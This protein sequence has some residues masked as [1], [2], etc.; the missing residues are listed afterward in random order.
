MDIGQFLE[1]IFEAQ[2]LKGVENREEPEDYDREE[3]DMP[4]LVDDDEADRPLDNH[5][6]D[7]A[8]DEDIKTASLELKFLLQEKRAGRIIN[9]GGDHIDDLI[10]DLREEIENMVK[11]ALEQ[12]Y[13]QDYPE[14][15]EEWVQALANELAAPPA[16]NGELP[17]FPEWLEERQNNTDEEDAA[18]LA[19]DLAQ[20]AE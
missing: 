1:D 15:Y 4:D 14:E 10:S 12:E 6:N 20:L 2:E 11:F 5:E 16:G 7:Y 17:D 18:D 9:S 19:V 8:S 13:E 3:V